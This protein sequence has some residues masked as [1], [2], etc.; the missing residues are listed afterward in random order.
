MASQVDILN[1]ALILIG[2]DT[3]TAISDQSN[4]ARS[5]NAVYNLERDNELRA[6]RWNFSIRRSKLPA[7]ASVPV[8]GPYTQ[9]FQL[10]PQSLR[11]LDVG[12]SYSGADLSDYRTGPSNADYLI[13]GGLILSNL[14]APLSLRDIVQ[15]TDPGLFDICFAKVLAC[16]MARTAC[17]RISNSGQLKQDILN[18][19]KSALKDAIRSNALELPPIYP[20]DDSW[21]TARLGDGG[22][23]AF[24]NF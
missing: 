5:L 23:P 16:R 21:V 19:H 8:T 4:Q 22:T 12:D 10:P 20:A 17:Y 2:A 18:E 6:H 24:V 14:P 3:I 15:V 9:Q 13:E 11:V 7:L 1:A